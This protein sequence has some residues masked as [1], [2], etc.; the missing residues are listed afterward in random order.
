MSEFSSSGRW[1]E[2]APSSLRHFAAT[3][4]KVDVG[5]GQIDGPPVIFT[6][7]LHIHMPKPHANASEAVRRPRFLKL[8]NP[9]PRP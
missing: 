9:F 4:N 6:H 3:I 7:F 5:N 2:N 1:N 8:Q